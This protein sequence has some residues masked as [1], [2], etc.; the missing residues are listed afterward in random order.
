MVFRQTV[1]FCCGFV[2]AVAAAVSYAHGDVEGMAFCLAA[3]VTACIA[4]L[5]LDV[6]R[7]VAGIDERLDK[8]QAA[9]EEL[10]TRIA[11]LESSV[12]HLRMGLFTRADDDAEEAKG[13]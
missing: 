6:K 2:A 10:A 7:D 4:S 13:E 5:A 9:L 1:I 8:C 3:V 11:R 12:G